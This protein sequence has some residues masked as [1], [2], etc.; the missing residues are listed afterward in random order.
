MFYVHIDTFK[1]LKYFMFRYPIKAFYC[2][3]NQQSTL[4]RTVTVCTAQHTVPYRNCMYSTTHC[5]VP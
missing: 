4:H 3:Y 1:K 5:T 2:N